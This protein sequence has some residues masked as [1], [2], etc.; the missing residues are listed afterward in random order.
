MKHGSHGDVVKR[1]KRAEGHLRHTIEMIEEGRPCPD[2]AQQLHAV[3][4][5]IEQ[6]KRLYIHDHID[7]CLDGSI[8]DGADR[9]SLVE[10]F[11]EISKYL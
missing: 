4:K 8:E 6:A 9:A 7:H 1:L 3:S 10:E 5:A 11:K 2:V